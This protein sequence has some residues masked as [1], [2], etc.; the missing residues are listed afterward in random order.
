MTWTLESRPSKEP[1]RDL[2]GIAGI[3]SD[4]RKRDPIDPRRGLVKIVFCPN[5]YYRRRLMTRF[6]CRSHEIA[7]SISGLHKHLTLCRE[8]GKRCRNTRNRGRKDEFVAAHLNRFACHVH[9]N[10]GSWGE[11]TAPVHSPAAVRDQEGRRGE[12][13]P[14]NSPAR[15]HYQ[16]HPPGG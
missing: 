2:G 1:R 5:S 7:R 4:K 6:R 9:Q 16:H 10:P 3:P 12:A 13:R 14:G 11:A 15:H 8:T